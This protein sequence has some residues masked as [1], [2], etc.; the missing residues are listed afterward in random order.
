MDVN[1]TIPAILEPL[2]QTIQSFVN[3]VQ[4]LVGGI[5][6]LYLIFLILRWREARELRKLMQ[7]VRDELKC[8]NNNIPKCKST[9]KK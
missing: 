1:S 9:K 2:A 6:G 7:E 5:F 4:F 8:L 3:V